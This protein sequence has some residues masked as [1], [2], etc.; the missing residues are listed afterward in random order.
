MRL[1]Q[2]PDEAIRDTAAAVFAQPV[3]NRTTLLDR[4]LGWLAE[5]FEALLVR[6]GPGRTPSWLFWALI[7]LTGALV[8]AV[9]GRALYGARFW[10]GGVASMLPGGS[11][12]RMSEDA[13]RVARELAA[14]GDFTAAAH[15]LYAALLGRIARQ[16]EVELHESKT[17]GDYIRDLR[18]RSSARLPG[19]REFART[20]ETVIYGLGTCDRDRYERLHGMAQRVVQTG[21]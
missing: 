15:A 9:V 8:L 10:P 12:V 13:W 14:R 1:V 18:A 20:Y 3:Y 7:L 6:L 5:V 16:G 19:F 21:G 4:L 11:P 2:I 17:V